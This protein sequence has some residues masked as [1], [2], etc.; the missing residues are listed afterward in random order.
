MQDT[1]ALVYLIMP[2]EV[3]VFIVRGRVLRLP[4]VAQDT[5]KTA[6]FVPSVRMV[7]QRQGIRTQESAHAIYLQERRCRIRRG[8]ILAVLMRIMPTKKIPRTGDFFYYNSTLP[9]VA[10][11]SAIISI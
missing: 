10:T 8:H 1:A 9:L 2:M 11:K 6:V 4:T 7:G 3:S 5:T